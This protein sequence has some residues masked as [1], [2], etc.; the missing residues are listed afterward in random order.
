MI[1]ATTR[2][3]LQHSVYAA[4][5]RYATD[6]SLE[7]AQMRCDSVIETLPDGET[8]VVRMIDLVCMV[9]RSMR[10]KPPYKVRFCVAESLTTRPLQ[11]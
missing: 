9:L 11:L 5:T 4:A 2:I 8:R 7:Y 10:A 3:Y 1:A 6:V